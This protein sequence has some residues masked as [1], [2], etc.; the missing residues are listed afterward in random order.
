MEM[1][2]GTVSQLMLHIYY[3]HF[4]IVFVFQIA[5]SGLGKDPYIA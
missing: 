2:A 4:D 1:E 5:F 3:L